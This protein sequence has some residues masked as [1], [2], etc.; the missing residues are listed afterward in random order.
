MDTAEERI[1]ELEAMS[2]ETSKTEKQRE[3]DWRE[4]EKKEKKQYPKTVEQLQKII[5]YMRYK[6]NTKMRREKR[7]EEM[8]G[9]IMT[10]SPS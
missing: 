3:K 5:T 8:F 1:S 9:A 4:K 10:I 7:I 2:V 6:W